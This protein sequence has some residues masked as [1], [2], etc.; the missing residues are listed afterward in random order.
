MTYNACHYTQ[1]TTYLQSIKHAPQQQQYSIAA[2]HGF[3]RFAHAETEHR[4]DRGILRQR[5]V[6]PLLPSS[7][8]SSLLGL[9][10]SS[11]QQTPSWFLQLYNNVS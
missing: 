6:K 9:V 1:S 5:Y 2:P 8:Q 7:M 11:A 4:V 3:I 10:A